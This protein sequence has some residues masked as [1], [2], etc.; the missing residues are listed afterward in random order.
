MSPIPTSREEFS[1]FLRSGTTL[2]ERKLLTTIALTEVILTKSSDTLK[3]LLLLAAEQ[4]PEWQSFIQR[5][6]QVTFLAFPD[7]ILNRI[8]SGQG[9]QSYNYPT[10]NNNDSRF[11]NSNRVTD[12]ITL[13]QPMS[14]RPQF[15]CEI[16]GYKGHSSDECRTLQH[17]LKEGWRR[18]NGVRRI[19][20]NETTEDLQAKRKQTINLITFTLLTQY[21]LTIHSS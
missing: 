18:P 16:Q 4:A 8:S 19:D 2:Y 17:M 3:A 13:N 14:R 20:H 21:V 11:R 1:E 6:E 10:Y 5:A 12:K 15:Y 7:K 9:A